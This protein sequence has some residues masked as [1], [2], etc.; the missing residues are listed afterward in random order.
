M[1]WLLKS[2]RAS[3]FRFTLLTSVL[4]VAGCVPYPHQ[5]TRTPEIRASFIRGV[6]PVVGAEVLIGR[7]SEYRDPCK[8]ARVVGTTDDKGLLIVPLE[9][10]VEFWYSLLN[11]PQTVGSLTNLCFRVPGESVIFG[12]Q[13]FNKGQETPTFSVVCDPTLPTVRSVIS[14]LQICR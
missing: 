1:Y 8:G 14:E 3:F 11:P 2:A 13:F 5:F 7:N 10:E 9:I 4:L 6:A 12:G